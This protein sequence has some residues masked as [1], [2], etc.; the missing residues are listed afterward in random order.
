MGSMRL[1]KKDDYLY[2]RAKKGEGRCEECALSVIMN[3]RGIGGTPLGEQLR[4]H[5]FGL[6]SSVRY[7]VHSKHTCKAFMRKSKGGNDERTC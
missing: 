1:K 6:G 2:R 3:V 4:C 5:L 7:R